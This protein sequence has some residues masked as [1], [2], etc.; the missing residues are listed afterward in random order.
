M[1]GR[2]NDFAV[3]IHLCRVRRQ[4][5]TYLTATGQLPRW[6]PLRASAPPRF[7]LTGQSEGAYDRIAKKLFVRPSGLEIQ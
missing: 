1:A 3:G 6:S 2:P 7:H 5:V 4:L